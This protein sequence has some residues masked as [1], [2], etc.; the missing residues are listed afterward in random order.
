MGLQ[1]IIYY[2]LFKGDFSRLGVLQCQCIQFDLVLFCR[3]FSFFSFSKLMASLNTS[4][5]NHTSKMA[6]CFLF[7][8]TPDGGR[9]GK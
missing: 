7:Q 5:F 1:K 6:F 8:K 2:E 9:T 4:S 3:F